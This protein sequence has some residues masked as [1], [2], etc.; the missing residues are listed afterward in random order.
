M[1][2]LRQDIK[3]NAREGSREASRYFSPNFAKQLAINFDL[4]SNP[5]Y[6][7]KECGSFLKFASKKAE[8]NSYYYES[9]FELDMHIPFPKDPF[10]PEISLVKLQFDVTA[11]MSL[12]SNRM[13]KMGGL[14]MLRYEQ[15]SNFV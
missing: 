3:K 2:I 15:S 5:D 6:S 14:W 11:T 1:H 8:I 10:T 13:K 9:G 4:E 12:P 7:K